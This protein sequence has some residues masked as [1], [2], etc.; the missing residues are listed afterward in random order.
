V[1]SL[2]SYMEALTPDMM[3]FGD[4]HLGEDEY[5]ESD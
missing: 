4:E 1:S 2:N 3:A 5:L